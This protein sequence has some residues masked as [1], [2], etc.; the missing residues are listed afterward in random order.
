MRG[1]PAVPEWRQ[2]IGAVP[3]RGWSRGQDMDRRARQQLRGQKLEDRRAGPRGARWH[4]VRG[5][6]QVAS[7][8]EVHPL[9]TLLHTSAALESAKVQARLL[10]HRH[11]LLG[12]LRGDAP[13]WR[14]RFR[15]PLQNRRLG[16]GG[17]PARPRQRPG[18]DD[19][20][21]EAQGRPGRRGRP[22]SRPLCRRQR[23]AGPGSS[24]RCDE[25]E[26]S[27]RG[28]PHHSVGRFGGEGHKGLAELGGLGA[29]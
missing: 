15:W 11:L 3:D 21:G 18:P 7:R 9:V 16:R 8:A 29:P 4:G 10:A 26:S 6:L 17:V 22:R 23:L 13:R 25:G 14:G 24:R 1:L 19:L 5:P 20:P 2:E 28:R 27:P 12:A